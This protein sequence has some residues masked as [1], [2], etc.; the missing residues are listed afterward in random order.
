V[1]DGT[2]ELADE[3]IAR[4]KT[5]VRANVR[6]QSKSVPPQTVS[7]PVYPGQALLKSTHQVIA[8]GA[9][10]GGTEALREFLTALPP[11]APG[12]VIVQ[13]MPEK[14]TRSFAERLNGLCRIR[15]REACDGDRVLPGHALLAPGNYHMTVLRSGA[16]YRVNV[17]TAEPV[18]RHR[19]SVDV[20]F[21]SCARDLGTNA[22]GIIMTGMG[23]DGARGLLAMRRAGARTLA[24]D[25]AS[26][27]VFGMPKEAIA[28]GAA[29]EV[30]SLRK[31]PASVM[32]L[33]TAARH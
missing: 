18:N 17:F 29:E 11:D 33:L 23:S 25:E 30:T 20:L 26:C 16:D 32:R 10:T 28:L 31:L 7:A 1:R 12:I 8:V 3:I 13:H 15:V 19:P 2:V 6:S 21:E 9:S 24:Q 5:A 14:F 22:I 27:V 4:I